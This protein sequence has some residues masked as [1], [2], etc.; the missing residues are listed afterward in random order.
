[1][2]KLAST[3]LVVLLVGLAAG[4][5][6]NS[7]PA[8]PKIPATFLF[9]IDARLSG[10]RYLFGGL[11]VCTGVGQYA[12]IHKG[13]WVTVTNQVGKPIAVG[14]VTIGVGTNYYEG[15]L[16]ECTFRLLVR[17]VPRAKAYLVILGREAPQPFTLAEVVDGAG[18]LA[19]DANPPLVTPAAPQ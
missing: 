18:V 12:D 9:R 19:F 15:A 3:V 16:D 4:C 7:G 8:G 17:N 10:D 5:T 6:D 14:T 1:M 13:A 11:G 2:R